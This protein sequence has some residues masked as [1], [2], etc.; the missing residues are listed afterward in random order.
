MV[1]STADEGERLK[2]R[3]YKQRELFDTI[4]LHSNSSFWYS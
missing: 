4:S 2:K 1:A 3:V